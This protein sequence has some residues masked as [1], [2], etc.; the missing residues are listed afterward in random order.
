VVT[1]ALLRP[2]LAGRGNAMEATRAERIG[3]RRTLI[4]PAVNAVSK[5]P[6]N[7]PARSL[8]KK[9]DSGHAPAEVHQYVAGCMR[10]PRAVG[11]AVMPAKWT[12]RVP[13]SMMIRA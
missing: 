8:I 13:C 10:C 7:W 6:V 3:L 12:R 4:R 11:F 5:E 9:L 1:A 2:G